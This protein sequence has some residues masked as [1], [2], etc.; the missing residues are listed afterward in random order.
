MPT[1]LYGCEAGHRKEVIHH[2]GEDPLVNCDKC[3]GAMHRIPQLLN[4]NWSGLNVLS[5]EVR[6][7]IDDTDRRRDEVTAKY[8][9]RKE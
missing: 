5:P 4:V 3:G 9:G 6:R 8:A 7:Y 2:M 1:Y